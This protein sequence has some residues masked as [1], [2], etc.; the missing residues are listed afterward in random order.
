MSDS[1]AVQKHSFFL[2]LSKNGEKK[3]RW[4]ERDDE[5]APYSAGTRH[6]RMAGSFRGVFVSAQKPV[7]EET[8][9]NF[10]K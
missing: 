5:A 9:E 4:Q 7:C 1:S 10:H 8:T 2:E 6:P 3:K